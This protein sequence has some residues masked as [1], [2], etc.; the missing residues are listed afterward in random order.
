MAK[1]QRRCFC[2]NVLPGQG[3]PTPIVCWRMGVISRFAWW[4]IGLNQRSKPT[5]Q[6]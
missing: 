1:T 5:V 6:R 2:H 3:C 4:L